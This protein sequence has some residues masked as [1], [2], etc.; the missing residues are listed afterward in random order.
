MD[1]LN[2]N[3]DPLS[4]FHTNRFSL[5]KGHFVVLARRST[6]TLI[7]PEESIEIDFPTKHWNLA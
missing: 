7:R 5:T 1:V 3:K 4:P 6:F 2:V